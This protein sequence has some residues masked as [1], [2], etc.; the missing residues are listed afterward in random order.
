MVKQRLEAFIWCLWIMVVDYVADNPEAVFSACILAL[1][2]FK[3]V[4]RPVARITLIAEDRAEA[5]CFCPVGPVEMVFNCF[6]E[7]LDCDR[8]ELAC[9]CKAMFGFAVG[10]GDSV[11]DA[12]QESWWGFAFKFSVGNI[13]FL[14]R[15]HFKVILDSGVFDPLSAFGLC[16][17]SEE[18]I[19]PTM[20]DVDRSRDVHKMTRDLQSSER[21]EIMISADTSEQGYKPFS[22][23]ESALG[24]VEF[25]VREM[26]I[27]G[28]LRHVRGRGRGE[29]EGGRL[30]Q[31]QAEE[32]QRKA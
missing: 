1:Q 17:G 9:C 23:F 32:R 29:A 12:P 20:M 27:R 30:R 24:E 19:L 6:L 3:S 7:F 31:T 8:L 2:A 13:F 5:A 11:V 22:C 26:M 28:R 18:A 4:Q 25:G 21:N 10:L 16:L 14:S 15:L